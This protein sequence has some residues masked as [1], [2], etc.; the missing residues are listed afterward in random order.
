MKLY[1]VKFIHPPTLKRAHAAPTYLAVDSHNVEL[2]LDQKA[3]AIVVVCP[4]ETPEEAMRIPLVNVAC[5]R[6][7]EGEI[8]PPKVK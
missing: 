8:L 1:S 7:A 6:P 5:Y 4:G 3:G 2:Y